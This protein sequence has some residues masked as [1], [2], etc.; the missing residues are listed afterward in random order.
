MDSL[1]S[2]QTSPERR[3]LRRPRARNAGKRRSMIAP[4]PPMQIGAHVAQAQ[5]SR[6]KVW[7]RADSLHHSEPRSR[8]E[9]AVFYTLHTRSPCLV[10]AGPTPSSHTRF[11]SHQVIIRS[12]HYGQSVVVS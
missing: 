1:E 8:Q 11:W 4:I 6:P 10:K 7:G 9:L 5:R 3:P 12:Y 2:L